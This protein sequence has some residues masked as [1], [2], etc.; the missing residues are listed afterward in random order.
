[1]IIMQLPKTQKCPKLT[2]NIKSTQKQW[3]YTIHFMGIAKNYQH[4]NLSILEGKNRFYK[5]RAKNINKI[6]KKVEK[7]VQI[8]FKVRILRKEM[9]KQ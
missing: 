1:M 5:M 3:N 9:I 7:Q 6:K 2:M 4:Y 8:V